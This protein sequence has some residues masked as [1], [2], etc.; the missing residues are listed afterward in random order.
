M[1]FAS[2]HPGLSVCE[3]P[4][5]WELRT[6]IETAIVGLKSFLTIQ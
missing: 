5:S 4:V 3:Y 6:Q 2:D 1:F